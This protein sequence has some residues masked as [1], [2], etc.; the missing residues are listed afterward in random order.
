MS[1]CKFG[2]KLDESCLP[3]PRTPRC[4]S[5]TRDTKGSGALQPRPRLHRS[6]NAVLLP[7]WLR[8]AYDEWVARDSS[9]AREAECDALAKPGRRTISKE[10]LIVVVALD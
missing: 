7:L 10:R 2:T 4:R 3:V 8:L 5:G 9:V 1:A 6:R